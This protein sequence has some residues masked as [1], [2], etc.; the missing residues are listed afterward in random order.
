MTKKEL[1]GILALLFG[2]T[3]QSYGQISQGGEPYTFSNNLESQVSS[4]NLTANLQNIESSIRTDTI[5]SDTVITFFDPIIGEVF[6]TDI[7]QLSQGTWDVLGNNDKIWRL[8][9]N[10]NAG[11]YM[12]LIFDDFYLP[13]G[14]SLYIYSSDKTQLLGSFTSINNTSQNKF[15]TTPLKCNSLLLEYYKPSWVTEQEHLNIQS[16]GLVTKDFANIINKE[17]GGSGDCMINAK[18]PQYE[19][20]CNQR[21]AVALII[22]VLQGGGQI[23]W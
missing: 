11:R 8:K 10:S 15:T 7:N 14:T 21:R 1:I 16:I 19:N 6:P 18:C 4:Y 3:Q 17:L 13:Q 12:M 2:L 5:E 9:V 20:C 22:R 23:R